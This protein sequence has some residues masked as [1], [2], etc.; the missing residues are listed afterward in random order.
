MQNP[1]HKHHYLPVFY[2]RRWTGSDGRLEQFHQPYGPL[3][4]ARRLH[5]EGIG[6][7][8]Q[9]Y[10]LRG[11]EP[12]LAQQIETAFFKPVDNLAARALA[13]LENGRRNPEW[14]D[15]TR[16]A[17]SR[18]LLSLIM[19]HPAA[20]RD[21]KYEWTRRIFEI[22]PEEEAAYQ[23]ERESHHPLTYREYLKGEGQRLIEHSALA[24]L[25]KLTDHEGS[26]QRLNNML[27]ATITTEG[28][29]L[30]FLT[31]DDP[32]VRTDGLDHEAVAI[33]L[34]IGLD[35]L[36][37]A[38]R[39]RHVIELLLNTKPIELVKRV[40]LEI[41]TRANP[42]STA[43]IDPSNT[44]FRSTC[45]VIGSPACLPRSCPPSSTKAA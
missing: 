45:R 4:K 13:H 42:M 44:S 25:L 24:Q 29:Y 32:V 17:W 14:D 3:V 21:L 18:F 19:R 34:P 15:D 10:E 2:T 16:S 38:A 35:L 12:A 43:P 5:P 7:V 23:I 27:W 40:N 41:V 6:Y 33:T 26:G 11:L 36:F 22:T 37:V 28:S 31:C 9:L 8:D 30:R 20:I 39:S 1:S